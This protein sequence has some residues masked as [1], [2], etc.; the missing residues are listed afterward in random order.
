M[1]F[2]LND[3]ARLSVADERRASVKTGKGLGVTLALEV[4]DIDTA[5]KA[6]VNAGLS[7]TPIRNHAWNARVFYLFD[8]EGHRMEFWQAADPPIP[9]PGLGF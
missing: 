7:P 3:G 2:L 1:E 9:R 5:F 8:P 6:T 4:E